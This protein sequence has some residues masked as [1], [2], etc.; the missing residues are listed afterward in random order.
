V[1]TIL[2]TDHAPHTAEEKALDFESAPFGIVGL[3]TA[4]A[5]YVEALVT[6]GRIGWPRLIELM[7]VTPARL[8]GLDRAGLGRLESGGPGDVTIID[9]D[10]EWTISENDLAGKGRNTPFL[11]RRVRGRAV[12]TIVAGRTAWA[13]DGAGAQ[14]DLAAA[15]SNG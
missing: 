6:G 2:A 8:C 10:L 4:L 15:R 14:S 11:G 7:T 3:E 5:L 9:P 13:L 12:R 1:I